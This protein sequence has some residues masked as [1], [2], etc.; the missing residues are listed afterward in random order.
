ME[1]AGRFGT[2]T[3]CSSSVNSANREH[4]ALDRR[5]DDLRQL[6]AIIVVKFEGKALG[7]VKLVNKG[8]GLEE[9][10]QLKLEYEGKSGNR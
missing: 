9:W 10:R 5:S 7:I 8:E 2:T 4:N 3:G 1:R 6:C